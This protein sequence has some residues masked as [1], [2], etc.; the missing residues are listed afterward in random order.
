MHSGVSSAFVVKLI[1]PEIG[2][3]KIVT[4]LEDV[5]PGGGGVRQGSEEWI[6]F[7][8]CARHC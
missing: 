4:P 5:M 3:L 2:G 8:D 6:G 7:C 1:L